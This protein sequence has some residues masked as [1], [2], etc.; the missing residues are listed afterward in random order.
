MKASG[1]SLL[2]ALA[3]IA[4]VN[5]KAVCQ[6]AFPEVLNNGTLS[7]QMK[8]IEEKT[9]IYE[10]FRAIREDMFQKIKVNSLDS[11]NSAKS[12]ITDLKSQVL[13]L[14][15]KINTLDGNLEDTKQNLQEM[16]RTKNSISV[17]GLE[18]NKVTYNS[19]MWIIIAALAGIFLTGLLA[20]K[21]NLAV[22]RSTRKEFEELKSEFENYRQK[23][24]L[25]REKMSM[26]HFNEI[27][28]LKGK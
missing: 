3:I 8:Y 21:R 26:D 2:L 6:G 22:T 27:K 17:L 20:F 13:S 10:D 14:N 9:R 16:T 19:I 4:V 1:K 12:M 15:E 28:R 5:T 24:R 18:I 11:L 23:S 7:D 25:E